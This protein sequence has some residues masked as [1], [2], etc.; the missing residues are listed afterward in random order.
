MAITKS[1]YKY[2]SLVKINMG[3]QRRRTRKY[4]RKQVN[5]D[6]KRMKAKERMRIQRA[7]KKMR[8]QQANEQQQNDI[9]I[10]ATSMEEDR[11][12]FN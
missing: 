12:N 6:E 2:N 8:I 10:H 9:P 7:E 1:F 11:G 3:N 4:D 5:E